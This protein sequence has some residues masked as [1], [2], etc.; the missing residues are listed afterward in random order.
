MISESLGQSPILLTLDNH[1]DTR[2]AFHCHVLYQHA[3]L[4][5]EDELARQSHCLAI[6]SEEL[7]T[8]E[9]AIKELQNDEQIDAAIRASILDFAMVI[10]HTPGRRTF[11]IEE[12]EYSK[13]IS[14]LE[15]WVL[16]PDQ[17]IPDRP[18]PPFTYGIPPSRIFLSTPLLDY[19]ACLESPQLVRNLE[20]LKQMVATSGLSWIDD[21]PYILDIDLDFFSSK[22]SIAPL[23]TSA[24]YKLLRNAAA[25]T[26]ALEPRYV[27]ELNEDE[28]LDSEYLFEKIKE[29]IQKALSVCSE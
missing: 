10:H 27:E 3:T 22:K 28:G 21:K 15:Y 20:E 6:R 4:K 1:T 9:S 26:I 8:I 16:H 2:E 13:Q 5:Y 23:D 29:H 7:K 25:I 11:S 19:D 12:K 17:K 18:T 14:N 24:F